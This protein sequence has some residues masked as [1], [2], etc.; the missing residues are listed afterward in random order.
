MNAS[1]LNK[2]FS[3][4]ELIIAISI[5][6]ILVTLAVPGLKNMLQN[7][8]MLASY[9][10]LLSAL[11]YTRS[12]AVTSGKGA[13]I[14]IRNVAGDNCESND[15]I[16][17]WSNGW[18][19]YVE[20]SSE[21]IRVFDGLKNSLELSYPRSK[22]TFN[23]QGFSAGYAGKFEFCDSRGDSAKRGMVISGTGRI[24]MADRNELSDCSVE[25]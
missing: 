12:A 1:H 21:V 22:L 13:S 4:I 8:A 10:E 23:S 7:N 11:N 5:F 19:V 24:R 16:A 14:C 9:N 2:G 20:S 6:S 25:E 15:D 18:I 3:L 17:K